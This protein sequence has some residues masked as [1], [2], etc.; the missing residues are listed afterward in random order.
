MRPILTFSALASVLLLNACMVPADPAPKM[1]RPQL[2][3]AAQVDVKRYAG[4]WYEVARYPQWLQKDCASAAAEYSLNADGSIT[5]LNTCIRADGSKRSVEGSAVPVDGTNSRLKVRFAK[6][7]YAAAI[8]VP[9]EGNYWVI[10]LTPDYRHA[11]VGTPDR[12]TLW[13]LSRSPSLSKAEFARMKKV[14]REQGFDPGRLVIDAH[15]RIGN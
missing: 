11:I 10:D 12:R 2:K 13:F 6:T 15:T 14:A 9:K 8:P 7:W 1:D 3:T 4:K 5:V